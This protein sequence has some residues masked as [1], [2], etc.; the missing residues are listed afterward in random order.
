MI[1]DG[2]TDETPAILAAIRDPRLQVIRQ[3]NAGLTRAL[4]RGCAEA[5]A[6][7]IARHDCD[8]CS[9][10]WA[11]PLQAHQRFPAHEERQYRHEAVRRRRGG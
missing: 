11:E 2:S 9:A 5:R 4:I 1:D 10:S 7:V 8:E 3:E 6:D